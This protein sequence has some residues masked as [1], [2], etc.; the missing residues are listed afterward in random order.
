[1]RIARTKISSQ[2]S[3]LSRSSSIERYRARREPYSILILQN[4][5]VSS[6]VVTKIAYKYTYP[7]VDRA[8]R[9]FLVFVFML[10]TVVTVAVG[11]GIAFGVIEVSSVTAFFDTPL[12]TA[13]V[14]RTFPSTISAFVTVYEKG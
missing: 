6:R 9:N 11:M 4:L 1:M 10:L 2:Y 13:S 8:L 7:V 12:A 14:I 3:L 5:T